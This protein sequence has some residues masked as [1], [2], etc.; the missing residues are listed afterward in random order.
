GDIHLGLLWL[1]VLGIFFFN[2]VMT[3]SAFMKAAHH[4]SE[5]LLIQNALPAV[6]MMAVI[7]LFWQWFPVNQNYLWIYTLSLALSGVCSFY[8]LRAWLP[9]FKNRSEPF[10]RQDVFQ[11]SIPLAPVSFFA[12]LMLWADTLMTG[13]LLQNEDVALFTVAARLSFV[14]GIFLGAMDATIYPRLLRINKQD[15][16]KLRK[17]FWQATLLVAAILTVVTLIL[18]T[19]GKPVLAVFNE[20]YVQATATLVILLVGQLVRGLGL[21]FSF[22]FI[23]R[24]QVRY[25]NVLLFVALLANLLA[26]WL[27]IPQYGIEGAAMAT[28]AAN[29]LLTG[30]VIVFFFKNRLLSGYA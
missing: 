29:F 1:A 22:M 27:L 2:L 28:L 9:S 6:C 12:Y 4:I 19:I 25:L 5:S 15:P 23:I 3:N 21:T 11:G 24:E 17:F 14:S 13:W 8:W 26:N 16:A 20:G 30:G 18:A 10:S 7:L